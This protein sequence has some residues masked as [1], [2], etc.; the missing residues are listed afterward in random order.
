[1]ALGLLNLPFKSVVLSYADEVTPV[2]LIGKK[3]LPI[4]EANGIVMNESL[5]IM[6]FL[7]SKATLKIPETRR[8]RNFAEFQTLLSD[9]GETIHSL[10]MPYWIQTQEFDDDSRNYFRRKKEAKRGSFGELLKNQESFRKT[11]DLK[12]LPVEAK[13]RPFFD[14]EQLGFEDL[15][16]VSHLWGMYV[17]PE[18]QFSQKAHRYLQ[19]VKSL[20]NFNYHQDYWS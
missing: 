15:L 19:S 17:V 8:S 13:L 4:L 2:K 5:D 12:L 9:L 16:L 14:S 7:D 6:A 1:M 18:F 20:C 11:L 10:A 3:M